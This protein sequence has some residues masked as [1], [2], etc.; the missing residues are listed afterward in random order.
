VGGSD[1]NWRIA[2]VRFLVSILSIVSLRKVGASMGS[3]LSMLEVRLLAGS[4]EELFR[5]LIP[6]YRHCRSRPKPLFTRWLGF[7]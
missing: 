3:R 2:G 4:M 7:R 1:L 5:A 6:S